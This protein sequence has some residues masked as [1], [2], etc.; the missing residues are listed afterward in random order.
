VGGTPE[1]AFDC[2]PGQGNVY[3]VFHGFTLDSPAAGVIGARGVVEF[4]FNGSAG[5]PPWWEMVGGCNDGSLTFAYLRGDLCPSYGNLL[6][7][8]STETCSGSGVTSM[9]YGVG[10]PN[11]ARAIITVMRPSD[12]PVDLP[13]G[14][15]FAWRLQFNI[16]N[17]MGLGPCAGCDAGPVVINLIEV[18]LSL[19]G[20]GSVAIPSIDFCLSAVGANQAGLSCFE[21]PITSKTWGR[22]KTLY[23]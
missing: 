19:A 12:S 3:E 16:D 1:I 7:G 17:P 22:L 9:E 8:S 2:T 5:V 20:G 11:R 15:N 10:A 14:R 13:T 6:C 4:R 21:T 18:D 23:R